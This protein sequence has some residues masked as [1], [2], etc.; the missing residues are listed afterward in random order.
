MYQPKILSQPRVWKIWPCRRKKFLK[1]I[2]LCY[3]CFSS[4]CM[5]RHQNGLIVFQT[6]QWLFL[7][8]IQ[9]EWIFLKIIETVQQVETTIYQHYC[10]RPHLFPPAVHVFFNELQSRIS[11]L[12]NWLKPWYC[13]SF[14]FHI[15][16]N[17]WSSI[18]EKRTSQVVLL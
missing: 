5:C 16:R 18:L 15:E 6:L 9:D 13:T 12:P 7:E 8:R 10:L 14:S 17:Y 2:L 3:H 1:V 11:F 4:W